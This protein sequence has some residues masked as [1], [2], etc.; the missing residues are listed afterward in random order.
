MTKQQVIIDCDPGIDDAL[1]LIY[2][3]KHPNLEV[4]AITIVCGN[5]PSQL[6]FEN[7][8]LILELVNRLDIPIY[9]GAKTPLK[10]PFISAQD[11]HGMDGLGESFLKRSCDKRPETTKADDYLA[12]Y[13]K[14]KQDTAILALGPLT[15]IA[16]ALE[17]NKDL[18][19]NCSRFISMGGN[20]KSNGNCSPVAEYNYWCDPHAANF[21]FK[22]LKRCV[23]M[24]GLDVTRKIVLSPNHLEYLKK[25]PSELTAFI[26]NI[27]RFYFDFHWKYEHLLGCVINDPLALAYLID[28][29]ICHGFTSYT[30]IVTDGIALGQSIVDAQ[31]FYQKDSNSKIL[32]EV[33]T[34]RFWQDFLTTILDQPKEIISQDILQLNLGGFYE[35]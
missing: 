14:Q 26:E 31:H 7:C 27:T 13:F 2:A 17:K 35:N 34:L 3:L 16:L 20:F 18:G 1:A 8:A 11:T 24:V 12:D 30:D 6:G 28:P 10:R 21:V 33:D 9:I 23:E 4:V 5:V 19:E 22:H 25:F 15:N 32:T 29:N